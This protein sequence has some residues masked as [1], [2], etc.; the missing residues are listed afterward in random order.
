MYHIESGGRGL[1]VI[2]FSSINDESP[3]LNVRSPLTS[4]DDIQLPLSS[5]ILTPVVSAHQRPGAE[6]GES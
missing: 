1:V 4:I 6:I 3:S 5:W 2:S